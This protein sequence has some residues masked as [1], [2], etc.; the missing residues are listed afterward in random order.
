MRT[1]AD[2]AAVAWNA[3]IYE[4]DFG[5]WLEVGGTSIA[6]PLIAGVYALAGNAATARSGFEYSH[7]GSLFNAPPGLGT[8][9]GTQAF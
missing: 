4:A 2:V 1:T 5:G 3:A 9:D 7:A 8:P 6:A